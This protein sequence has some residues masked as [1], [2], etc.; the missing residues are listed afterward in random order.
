LSLFGSSSVGG[1]NGHR[2]LRQRSVLNPGEEDFR[3]RTGTL[4]STGRLAEP[5]KRKE[6]NDSRKTESFGF[7]LWRPNADGNSDDSGSNRRRWSKPGNQDRRSLDGG[8]FRLRDG[9]P[10]DRGREGCRGVRKLPSGGDRMPK[11]TERPHRVDSGFEK[12]CISRC[13]RNGHGGRGE[14]KGRTTHG[15][16]CGVGNGGSNLWPGPL[17]KR[18]CLRGWRNRSQRDEKT[19]G[20]V[21]GDG[22]QSGPPAM[23]GR[24]GG[25]NRRGCHDASERL[26]T[27]RLGRNRG[28]RVPMRTESWTP[29]RTRYEVR[30]FWRRNASDRCRDRLVCVSFNPP[31]QRQ[32]GKA[33]RETMSASWEGKP[34]KG[35]SQRRY[36]CETEPEGFREEQDVRRLRKPEDAAQPGEASPVLVASRFLKRQRETNLRRGAASAASTVGHT[37]EWSSSP[38]EDARV[39]RTSEPGSVGKTS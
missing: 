28:L 9:R 34:L 17:G 2:M 22:F 4:V 16:P 35:E 15:L 26:L 11:Q 29:V 1:R 8:T 14:S 18:P 30:S 24:E 25:M 3:V 7:R 31:R 19:G 13:R 39:F 36:R 37:L 32:E 5:T 23:A 6:P 10:A 12:R 27:T 38:R 33:R 21:Y 20:N